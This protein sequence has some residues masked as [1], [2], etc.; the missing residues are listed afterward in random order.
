MPLP[1]TVVWRRL[2]LAGTG[3]VR[4]DHGEDGYVADGFEVTEQ[5]AV[6]FQVLV[7]NNWCTREARIE[8]VGSQ[9]TRSLVVT[10]D[11][12]GSW[13][14]DGDE[15]PDVKGCLD[16]DIAATP[17]TN[18]FPIRRLRLAPGEEAEIRALW[19]GVPDLDVEVVPPA[20]RRLPTD[21]GSDRYEYQ[22]VGSE[23]T[24]VIA[25]DDEG[26]AVDYE[27]FA[28]RIMSSDGT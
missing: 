22:A 3:L 6:R 5:G 7:D 23:H 24:Y 17:F 2:D 18:T 4:L 15:R 25:V 8:A 27:G 12:A 14:I 26:I 10:A 28:E 13:R 19:V 9:G 1:R 11:G 20:Y 16:I 21:D